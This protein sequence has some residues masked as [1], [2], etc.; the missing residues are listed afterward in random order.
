M[1]PKPLTK[2]EQS[3]LTPQPGLQSDTEHNEPSLLETDEKGNPENEHGIEKS[4]NDQ[5]VSKVETAPAKYSEPIIQEEQL[6]SQAQQKNQ[7]SSTNKAEVERPVEPLQPKQSTQQPSK[8]AQTPTES[9]P[10]ATTDALEGN[11]RTGQ[12]FQL[13]NK[14]ESDLLSSAYE[15]PDTTT[16]SPQR[17]SNSKPLSKQDVNDEFEDTTQSPQSNEPGSHSEPPYPMDTTTSEAPDVVTEPVTEPQSNTKEKSKDKSKP[18]GLLSG[19]L[20]GLLG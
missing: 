17:Y 16:A 14:S 20:G 10:K 1:Q 19:L 7:P 15:N 8:Q 5:P 4:T 9:P 6:S 18:K 11:T 2:N 3:K 12:A 13:K